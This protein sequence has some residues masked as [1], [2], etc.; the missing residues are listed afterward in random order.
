[1]PCSVARR[2]ARSSTVPVA[3][4]WP[5]NPPAKLSPAPVG[6]VTSSNG[7]A[8]DQNEK[9][10]VNSTEPY[11]PRF[12]TT[13]RGPRARMSRAAFA[14]LTVSHSCRASDSFTLTMSTCEMTSSSASRL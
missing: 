14:T 3:A 2:S 10:R 7:K 12:T 1:M 4:R 9:D 6:S 13:A 11:S 5:R 8:G